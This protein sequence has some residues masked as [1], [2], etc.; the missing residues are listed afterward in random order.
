LKTVKDQ[1]YTSKTFEISQD[2]NLPRPSLSSMTISKCKR[3]FFQLVSSI[4]SCLLILAE[5]KFHWT[6]QIWFHH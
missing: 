1:K 3:W 2:F 4:S 5:S 6:L